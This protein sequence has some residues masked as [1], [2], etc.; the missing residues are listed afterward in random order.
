MIIHHTG[1]QPGDLIQ[2]SGAGPVWKSI[3]SRLSI[4]A[5][6]LHSLHPLKSA[7]ISSVVLTLTERL[8]SLLQLSGCLTSSQ[9]S[10]VS[11]SDDMIGQTCDAQSW[12]SGACYGGVVAV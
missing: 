10:V 7:A 11:E 12:V 6:S 3:R 9:R 2:S 8:L 4:E 1:L 5:A